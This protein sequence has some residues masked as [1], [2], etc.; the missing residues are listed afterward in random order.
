MA[1]PAKRRAPGARRNKPGLSAKTADKHILYQK[2]VQ[3]ADAEVAFI[4]RIF[5]KLRKRSPVTLREDFCGTAL[6]TATWVKSNPK[7]RAIGVDIDPHVLE[8]GH[9]HNLAP[10]GEPGDRVTIHCQDVRDAVPERVEVVGAFNFS[11]W[12]FK[13]RDEL[14]GYFKRVLK[15]LASDGLFLLDAYGGWESQEPMHE[16]RPIRGGFTYIWD[17]SSFDPISHRVVNHIHFH[18][19]DGTK[20]ERAF[21]Y[22]WR[23]WTLPELT[24]VLGEAGFKQIDVYWDMS[25]DEDYED[26]RP[27][28]SAP[29]Q[30][31]WLAY[32][33]AQR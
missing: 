13:T 3:D 27:R 33:V 2:S 24:E 29:N 9:E 32:I 19:R 14:R 20:L 11:Y 10:I 23:Y 25:K 22:D 15:G 16:D 12:V 17:Q 1:R 6:L 28:R 7:R 8:W 30:P 5:K 4:E 18:F 31:G 21:T 26:Y